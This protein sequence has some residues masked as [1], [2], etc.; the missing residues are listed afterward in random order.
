V[1][2]NATANPSAGVAP[3][4]YLWSNGATSQL[5]TGLAAGTYTVTITD[6]NGCMATGS[7]IIGEYTPGLELL[8]LG[9]DVS[10]NGGSDGT[11]DAQASGGIGNYTYLWNTGAT[12]A[13]INS[14]MAGTYFVTVTSG[15]QTNVG[16]VIINQPTAIVLNGSVT[17]AS[18]GANGSVTVNPTGG[19]APYA[20]L[21]S[22]GNQTTPT[23]NDLPQGFY[24]CT[25]TDANGCTAS[26]LYTVSNTTPACNDEEISFRIQLDDHP[27]ETTWEIKDGNGQ[28]VAAGGPYVV[29]F[30]YLEYSLCLPPGCYDLTVFDAGGNGLGSGYYEITKNN[31]LVLNGGQFGASETQ[32]FCLG[33]TPQIVFERGRISTTGDGWQTVQLTNQYSNPVVIATPVITSTSLDPVVARVRNA[34]T[35]SFQVRAQRP[36]ASTNDTYD[37]EYFVVEEGVYDFPTYGV[38]MEAVLT[39]S[40]RTA[41]RG[42]WSSNYRETRS[43]QNAYLNPVVL[44]QVMSQNDADFS[45]FWASRSNSRTNAPT[46]T[47]F[48]AGKHVAEDND[49]TRSN[50]SL[51]YVV[52]EAG[53]GTINGEEYVAGVGSDIVRGQQ[54]NSLGYL[55][56]VP[57]N[58]YL[59]G[60]VLSSAAMDGNDGGWPVF[61]A[62]PIGNGGFLLA[63][64]EDQVRDNERNHTTEQAAYLVFGL[65]LGATPEGLQDPTEEIT[66]TETAPALPEII[67]SATIRLFPNPT[68]DL[69]NVVYKATEDASV[70]L[71]IW[72]MTGRKVM[73][74]TAKGTVRTSFDV[75]NLKAGIYLLDLQSDT[76]RQTKRFIVN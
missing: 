36:G 30:M 52:I 37:I 41:A 38:K 19:S 43:Y 42:R 9:T 23:I 62:D 5:A 50:E 61:K 20:Y 18:N 68:N 51:G 16:V 14:L 31:S 34:G 58:L 70:Q 72:D 12:T 24:T 28:T 1:T 35:N 64:E 8:V 47:S 57:N 27:G 66:V 45:V 29:D 4:T 11:A 75:S 76:D 22:I 17:D 69:L 33:T 15:S 48:A 65:D 44:G 54:N 13:T 73:E 25:V 2:G 53:S 56:N 59:L 55:Y 10:C 3:Y 74:Q 46:Q 21:W 39:T 63:I 7:T 49:Q 32:N 67:P 40:T 71:T 26:Q 6:A 60:G